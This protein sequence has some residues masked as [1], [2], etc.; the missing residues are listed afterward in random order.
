[1][2][3]PVRV[4]VY[5]NLISPSLPF[6]SFNSFICGCN[7]LYTFRSFRL[8]I[9][10][11]VRSIIHSFV[12][13]F[14]CARSF[15]FSFGLM[16]ATKG[17]LIYCHQSSCNQFSSIF[18][19]AKMENVYIKTTSFFPVKW[20]RRRVKNIETT[21]SIVGTHSNERMKENVRRFLLSL[22]LSLPVSSVCVSLF[23]CV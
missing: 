10:S 12:R 2:C 3:V 14:I 7:Y 21:H 9:H 22:S 15:T 6:S 4:G 18:F 13:T 5:I 17:F 20:S 23:V 1:M 16:I 19:V 11:C 8:L